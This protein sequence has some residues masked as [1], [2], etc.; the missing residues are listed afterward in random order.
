[1][2]LAL[3]SQPEKGEPMSN[4]RVARGVVLVLVLLAWGGAAQGQES[5]KLAAAVL[6]E[7]IT[8]H[9]RAGLDALKTDDH[10]AFAASIADD[11]IFIDAQGTARKAV[12]V[13]NTAAFRLRDYTMT[14]ITFLP[15]SADSGLI[16]YKLASTGTSHGHDFAATVYVSALWVKRNGTWLCA[17]S[18]ETP[19]HE[20]PR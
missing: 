16:A 15:L 13:K 2:G 8:L 18:Q 20:T 4:F 6:R 3:E 14:D 7:E 17:F 9:E 1:V 5:P 19:A 10:A 11:A 12:V